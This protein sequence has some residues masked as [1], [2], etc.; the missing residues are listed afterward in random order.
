MG[1]VLQQAYPYFWKE[2]S[3]SCCGLGR[4]WREDDGGLGSNFI[5]PCVGRIQHFIETE[6]LWNKIENLHKA[7]KWLQYN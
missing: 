3:E 7:I 5:L 1:E 2:N 4:L 6:A